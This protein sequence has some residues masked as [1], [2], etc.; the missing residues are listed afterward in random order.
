MILLPSHRHRNDGSLPK[1]EGEIPVLS[2]ANSVCE[3]S[4]FCAIGCPKRWGNSVEYSV[5]IK[6]RRT[7]MNL[8]NSDQLKEIPLKVAKNKQ[9]RLVI[10]N[11]NVTLNFPI[12]SENSD[13][14]AIKQLILNG[15]MRS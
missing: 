8:R 7:F 11:C 15:V 13:M 10:S 6:I 12:S 3:K 9:V 1:G 2:L 4:Q 5:K 14:N